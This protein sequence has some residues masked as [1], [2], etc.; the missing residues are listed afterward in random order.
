MVYVHYK[1]A[2]DCT[3][4]HYLYARLVLL[5]ISVAYVLQRYKMFIC[6][7]SSNYF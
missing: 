2:V 4:T 1:P 3:K 7:S 6:I 5:C